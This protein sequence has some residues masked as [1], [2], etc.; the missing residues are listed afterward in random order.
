MIMQNLTY[1]LTGRLTANACASFHRY[2]GYPMEVIV[3]NA[4]EKFLPRRSNLSSCWLIERSGQFWSAFYSPAEM[5]L[6]TVASGEDE[7][8]ARARVL[9]QYPNTELGRIQGLA[10]LTPLYIA[11]LKE[12]NGFDQIAAELP[13]SQLRHSMPSDQPL[14]SHHPLIQVH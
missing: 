4:S 10:A 3:E 9:A 1:R 11:A 5:L 8:A 7:R 2:L 6:A 13:P 12:G 14:D